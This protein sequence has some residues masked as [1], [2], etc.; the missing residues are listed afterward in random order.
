MA[1]DNLIALA[2]QFDKAPEELKKAAQTHYDNVNKRLKLTNKMQ[3]AVVELEAAN[4]AATRSDIEFKR[5][6]D[7]WDPY[8]VAK[9]KQAK[10]F[11]GNPTAEGSEPGLPAPVIPAEAE[12]AP[13]KTK[14]KAKTT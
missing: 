13:T 14:A 2:F 5:L 8:E 11:P 7:L 3:D 9:A 6:L 12:A 4:Q 1:K 10:E